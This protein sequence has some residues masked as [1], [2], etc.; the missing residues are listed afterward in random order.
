MSCTVAA[1]YPPSEK[2]RAGG[3]EHLAIALLRRLRRPGG[4]GGAGID[5]SVLGAGADGSCGRL[6]LVHERLTQPELLHLGGRHGPFG[7]E[8]D[9]ARNLEAGDRPLA[10]G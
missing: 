3:V 9:V 7:H 5:R 4:F 8:P 1:E 10:V 6:E 2:T